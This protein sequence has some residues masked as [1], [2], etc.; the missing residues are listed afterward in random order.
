MLS[1]W[2]LSCALTS[3]A[4]NEKGNPGMG[5]SSSNH[6]DPHASTL[7]R[8]DPLCHPGCADFCSSA[9]PSFR[10][11]FGPQVSASENDEVLSL[12]EIEIYRN[13]RAAF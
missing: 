7:I 3:K 11:T 13:F 5:I 4:E 9:F 1:A 8:F 12:K 10:F 2:A 6:F